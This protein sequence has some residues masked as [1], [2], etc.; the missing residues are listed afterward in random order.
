MIS[1]MK[2]PFPM[3]LINEYTICRIKNK[4]ILK[5]NDLHNVDCKNCIKVMK[6]GQLS[7]SEYLLFIV[8]LLSIVAFTKILSG[9]IYML[10]KFSKQD[11][12]MEK[13]EK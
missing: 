3:P 4:R 9:I 6:G 5:T 2:A 7:R 1:H 12:I 8:Q 11:A 10:P 13:K